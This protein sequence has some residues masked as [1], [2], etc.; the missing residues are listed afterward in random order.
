MNHDPNHTK[1]DC[2]WILSSTATF[3]DI[4]ANDFASTS[5]DLSVLPTVLQSLYLE[6]NELQEVPANLQR[7]TELSTM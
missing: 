4:S 5:L 1:T 6:S 2:D 7:L 3:R